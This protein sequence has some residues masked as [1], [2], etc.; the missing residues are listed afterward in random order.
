MPDGQE[1]NEVR[2]EIE[3]TRQDMSETI[4]AIADR[5][6]P[7]RIIDRRRRRA[8]TAGGPCGSGSWA[9]QAAGDHARSLSDSGRRSAGSVVDTARGVPGAVTEQ[10]QGNPIAAGLDGLRGRSADRLAGASQRA[11]AAAW[12]AP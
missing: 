9:A 3:D 6:S 7:R 4:D 8:P 2:A 12:P 5:T 1:R 11:G 10:T